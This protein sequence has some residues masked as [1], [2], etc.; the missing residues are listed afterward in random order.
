[1]V[2]PPDR[3]HSASNS[4]R[5]IL[6]NIDDVLRV[7]YKDL[8]NPD[9]SFV[10]SRFEEDVYRVIKSEASRLIPRVTDVS[11]INDDVAL[12]LC[13]ENGER[14]IT[15]C[16]SMVGLFFV[17]YQ[18]S[19]ENDK[20]FFSDLEETPKFVRPFAKFLADLGYL[21]LEESVV[22][23]DTMLYVNGEFLDVYS[24]LFSHV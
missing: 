19:P 6:R 9:Y 18:E 11:D 21:L 12:F 7:T 3:K 20:T 16:I 22:R 23:S 5:E 2:T 8:N 24:A 13:A 15:V 1:M 17:V 10:L 4:D 14:S